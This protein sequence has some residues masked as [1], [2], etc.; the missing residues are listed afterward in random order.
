VVV[1]DQPGLPPAKAALA[2]EI[3]A[4]IDRTGLG[5]ERLAARL[6]SDGVHVSKSALSR[7][8]RGEALPP[9][10]VVVALASLETARA[11][12][13]NGAGVTGLLELWCRAQESTPQQPAQLDPAA[14]RAVPEH[15]GLASSATELAAADALAERGPGSMGTRGG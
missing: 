15:D 13:P 6:T 7:Y 14:E 3:K 2:E 11:E 8:Q 9:R 1:D 12:R 10:S 5:L 4:R